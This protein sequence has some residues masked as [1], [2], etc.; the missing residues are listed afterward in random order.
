MSAICICAGS[1]RLYRSSP[2]GVDGYGISYFPSQPSLPHV[3]FINPL[4]LYPDGDPVRYASRNC[5]FVMKRLQRWSSMLMAAQ[6]RRNPS[7]IPDCL[8][9]SECARLPPSRVPIHYLR[10]STGPARCAPNH[11]LS[12]PEAFSLYAE[13]N[14]PTSDIIDAIVSPI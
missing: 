2:I 6:G 5:R 8:Y 7:Q 10:A 4:L 12:T 13:P 1:G 9:Y 14:I 3:E 11:H